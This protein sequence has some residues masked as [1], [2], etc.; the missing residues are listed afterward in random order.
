MKPPPR[1]HAAFRTSSSP[2]VCQRYS[3]NCTSAEPPGG[4]VAS[5]QLAKGTLVAIP[6]ENLDQIAVNTD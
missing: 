3:N 5:S 1:W 6:I 2:Y 4:G